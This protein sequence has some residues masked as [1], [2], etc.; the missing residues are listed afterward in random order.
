MTILGRLRNVECVKEVF[1]YRISFYVPVDYL[2][3]VKEAMFAAGAGQI[4][5]YSHCAW[6]VLGQGQFMPGEASSPFIGQAQQLTEVEEYYCAM[7][8]DPSVI[9]SVVLALKRAHPYEEP[10]YEVFKLED[11]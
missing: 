8:C 11:F 2:S 7:L 5:H 3:Q 9:K 1:L 4:G 10:A 6:Q